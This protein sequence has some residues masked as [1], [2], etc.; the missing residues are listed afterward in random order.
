MIFFPI[1]TLALSVAL[2]GAGAYGQISQASLDG[3]VRDNSGS[4]I[5]GASVSVKNKGTDFSR[6]AAAGSSGEYVIPNLEPAEYTFTVSFHGFKTFVV[7]SLA[8]HTGDHATVDATLE[9]GA[10]SQEVTIE[11]AV[12]LLATSSAEVSHLVPASQVA[13]LPLNGRNFWELT[14]L[15]PGATFIPRAQTAGFNGSELRARNVNVT[16][17]GSS[18]IF[19]GW[20]LDGANVTNFELGGTLISPNV[21]AIQEFSVAAANMAP[22]F[23]HTPNLVNASLKSGTNSFHGNL[24]EFLRNDKLDARNFFLPKVTPLKR[25]QFG[26]TVGGPIV[27]DRVFFFADYQGTRLRQGLSFNDVVPSAAERSGNFSDLLP[28]KVI[29]DP[30]TRQPFP[31]NVIPANRLS[32]QGAFFIPFLPLPNVVQGSTNRFIY[33]PSLQ[34][35]NDEGD[36]KVDAR[37]TE[38]DSLLA[39]YS[40]SDSNESNALNYPALG[41]TELK[42]KAQDATMRWTHIFGPNVL[43]AAQVSWYD[44]PFVF[45]TVLTGQN[46]NDQAGIQGFD[47]PIVTPVQSMPNINLTGYATLQGSPFDGRPKAIKVR[48]W[49]ESDS[50]S[51]IHGKHEIKFGGELLNIWSGFSVGQNSVGVWTFS[52]AYSGNAIADLLLGIPDSGTRGPYQ[53]LQ[54]D[55]DLFK[56]VHFNDTWRV[57]PGLTINVGFRWEINPFY[58]GVNLT[59]TGF[60]VATGKIIVPRGLQNLPTAQP[61]VPLLLPLFADRYVY[62]NQVGLPDSITPSDH[63]DIAPRVGIA[64]SPFGSDKWVIRSGY[65]IFFTYPDT[66]LLNHTVVTVPLSDNQTV[67]NNRAPAAPTRTFGN[68]YRGAPIASPNPNPGQPCPWGVVMISC[69]TPSV[70]SALVYLRNQYTHQWNLSIQRQLASRVALTV[71]YVGNRTVRLQSAP[72]VN[73]PA[74]G[75]GDIQS[76]RPYPQWGPMTLAQWS[77]KA[78][79]NALQNQIEVRDWRGLTLM[80]SYVYSKCLDTGTD[81]GTPPS[82]GL[83]GKNHA[84][85]DFDSTHVGSISFNYQL[86]V[87]KGK[88]FLGSAPRVV[89]A[90]LGGW[91]ISSVVT[92][93][94]GLPFTPAISSDRANIGEGGQRPRLI[95]MPFVPGSVNCW[96]YT[97]SNS[98]CR[99]LYPNLTDAFALPAQYA[100]GNS[101]RNILRADSLKQFDFSVMKLF[102]ISESKRVEIRGEIF[103][104]FNHPVFQAP[105]TNIDQSSGGQ[106]TATLNSD[107]II[108]FGVKLFF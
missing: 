87:G 81:E 73:D 91:Q 75:P 86:P 95:G 61:L 83:I 67:F 7:S 11:A 45:G 63:L 20:A 77:G 70:G 101:G 104:V 65:G 8:L 78:S 54:G 93:K 22:E 94:S 55:Y 90:A 107:R 103:N 13:E 98:S 92:L 72:N 79:Y 82:T 53:T 42:S 39:R 74:P 40:I 89:D 5:P 17:N 57:R 21:D 62:S 14:Q 26:G 12:P 4:V 23:G 52:G 108:E 37:I 27:K 56:A 60:D 102:S 9:L 64:W 58:K 34:Q 100:Y 84:V 96:F 50:V 33:A 106:V 38:R 48:T 76:R 31:G 18:Y 59:R 51:W 46:I 32:P 3:T 16:V 1:R 105:G 85:C 47:N 43:N 15:T 36:M 28:G 80:G 10:T 88:Q 2:V 35:N 97:S 68:F 99:A 25:N 66:N 69:D 49:N 44:S 29:V 41:G 19:T 6:S 24:F 71:A 30:L